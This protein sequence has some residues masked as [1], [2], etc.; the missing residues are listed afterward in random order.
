M[1]IAIGM[2]VIGMVIVILGGYLALPV[3]LGGSWTADAI[4]VGGFGALLMA[5]GVYII[6]QGSRAI[7]EVLNAR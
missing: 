5:G 6:H 1:T 2:Y 3:L 4:Y 7:S